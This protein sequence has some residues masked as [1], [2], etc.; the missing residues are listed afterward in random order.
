[1]FRVYVTGDECTEPLGHPLPWDL[2][3]QECWGSFK[4]SFG[5][6]YGLRAFLMLVFTGKWTY[7]ELGG[8][9]YYKI[10]RKR[11]HV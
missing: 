3:F 11:S 9:Y 7:Y 5:F 2:S 6:R 4:T 8:N 1:M 10:G